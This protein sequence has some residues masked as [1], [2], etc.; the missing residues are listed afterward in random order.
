VAN[1]ISRDQLTEPARAVA[2]VVAASR[3]AAVRSALDQLDSESA[4]GLHDLRVA[5]RRLRSWMRT[6]RR[7]LD[8]TVRKKTRRRIDKLAR[9]TDQARDAEVMAAS[10]ARQQELPPR[11]RRGVAFLA[12][13]IAAELDDASRKARGKLAARLPNTL[14]ALERQLSHYWRRI[15]VG[16]QR[17][18][19]T[20]AS[21]TA[22]LVGRQYRRFRRRLTR[23]ESS[24]D[25]A[26]MHRARIAAKR[27]RYL[28]EC[29]RDFS[30]IT[31]A[32]EQLSE[33][34]DLLGRCHD[35]HVVIARVF[36]EIRTVGAADAVRRAK[37]ALQLPPDDETSPVLARVRPGLVEIASRARR[38]RDETFQRFRELWPPATVDAMTRV[39]DGLTGELESI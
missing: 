29:L 4:D 2:R 24:D 30:G 33:L 28:L 14:D 11:T 6:Y 26:V 32:C 25:D 20:M 1:G 16:R 36:D 23:I 12:A 22:D 34:Q 18:E 15:A 10:L 8:D 37:L 19:Q 27:L 5:L 38:E 17:G 13:H 3:I 21:A 35:D 39:I 9:A 31:A 7:E